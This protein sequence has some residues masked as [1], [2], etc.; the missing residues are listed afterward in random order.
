MVLQV[1]LPPKESVTETMYNNAPLA[2]FHVRVTESEL[3]S[4]MGKKFWGTQGAK[5]TGRHC[6]TGNTAYKAHTVHIYT[7]R[8]NTIPLSDV[9]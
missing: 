4:A 8:L 3:Q 6:N 9:S 2:E 5:H 1:Y 7:E